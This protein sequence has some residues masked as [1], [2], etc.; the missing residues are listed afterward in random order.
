M[1]ARDL[2]KL[3]HERQAKKDTNDLRRKRGNVGSISE[4]KSKGMGSHIY[5][6]K[7]QQIIVLGKRDIGSLNILFENWEQLMLRTV[8]GL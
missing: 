3:F 1:I 2:R 4:L 6:H 7:A 5:T 8:P